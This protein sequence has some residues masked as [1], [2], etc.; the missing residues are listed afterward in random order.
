MKDSKNSTTKACFTFTLRDSPTHWVCATVWGDLIN[1][2]QISTSFS[3]G[4]TVLVS[5]AVVREKNVDPDTRKFRPDSTCGF[6]LHLND[7]LNSIAQ[8]KFSNSSIIDCLKSSLIKPIENHSNLKNIIA[9]FNLKMKEPSYDECYTFLAVVGF[10][11]RPQYIKSSKQTDSNGKPKLILKCDV[12]LF[13]QSC[14]LFLMTLWNEDF[15][16]HATKSWTPNRGPVASPGGCTII[17]SDPLCEQLNV[18]RQFARLNQHKVQFQDYDL[19]QCRDFTS[20]QIPEHI[21]NVPFSN[22][23]TLVTVRTLYH[24]HEPTFGI[25]IASFT[26]MALET[27]KWDRLLVIQCKSCQRRMALCQENDAAEPVYA[28]VNVVC[29]TADCSLFGIPT[30]IC[31]SIHV[32]VRLT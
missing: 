22:I 14:S 18:L 26:R 28:S 17:I 3:I 13:D 30:N 4:D 6:H 20:R 12:Y 8:F 16:A 25:L 27:E 5:N 7:S 24:L 9:S 29:N 23:H 11:S 31:N 15:I 2:A 32:S 1:I 21:F 19:N 10:V